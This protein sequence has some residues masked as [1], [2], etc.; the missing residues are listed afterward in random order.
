MFNSVHLDTGKNPEKSRTLTGIDA[1]QTLPKWPP[2][3]SRQWHKIR[4]YLAY[5][6]ESVVWGV[7]VGRCWGTQIMEKTYG[8]AMFRAD[9]GVVSVRAVPHGWQT[10]GA[11]AP[12]S[13]PVGRSTK[14]SVPLGRRCPARALPP[15]LTLHLAGDI[16]EEME[17]CLAKTKVPEWV[18]VLAGLS[19]LAIVAAAAASAGQSDATYQCHNCQHTPIRF[20][21]LRCPKCGQ[22]FEWDD[23]RG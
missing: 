11:G 18:W 8:L 7:S 22:R 10:L 2:T 19:G 20:G 14:I 9:F 13:L 16:I 12:C 5:G 23:E 17:V 6:L 21:Q 3:R 4:K 15:R 1:H